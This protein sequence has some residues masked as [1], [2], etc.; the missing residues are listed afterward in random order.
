MMTRL[1]PICDHMRYA[2]KPRYK[3]TDDDAACA[4]I[5]VTVGGDDV[6]ARVLAAAPTATAVV[7]LWEFAQFAEMGEIDG[8][9]AA[10]VLKR[11]LA[12]E[13]VS[14]VLSELMATT[15]LGSGSGSGATYENE[16]RTYALKV[17]TQ[18]GGD[19]AGG[20][21]TEEK[22]RERELGLLRARLVIGV[23]GLVTFLMATAPLEEVERYCRKNS[24]WA[25]GDAELKGLEGIEA[26]EKEEETEE[27]AG[28][29]EEEEE[30]DNEQK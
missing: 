27:V 6:E 13:V 28:D 12:T 17:K 4:D 23:V 2:A 22:E 10:K 21:E 20:L 5:I 7:D 18:V 19:G 8:T 3:F 15:G 24:T 25:T 29:E 11:S 14:P 30:E 26:S 16:A 1:A 9:G